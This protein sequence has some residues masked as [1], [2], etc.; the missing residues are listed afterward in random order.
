MATPTVRYIA[1]ILCRKL[2]SGPM[3]ASR[4]R[5]SEGPYFRGS[6]SIGTTIMRLGP[7]KV[8]VL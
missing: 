5:N 6:F 4:L 7:T 8:S 2:D 3:F 1:E